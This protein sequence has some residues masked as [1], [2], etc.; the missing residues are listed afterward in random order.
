MRVVIDEDIP[1]SLTPRFRAGGY[2]VD[3][4]EDIGLKGTHNG[5]LLAAISGSADILVTGDTSLGHQQNLKLFDLAIILVRPPRLVVDQIIPLIPEVV[6]AFETAKRHA[7]TTIGRP[8]V[9]RSE[10]EPSASSPR[11][12]ATPQKATPK[13][14]AP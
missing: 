1:A 12:P 7:V 10:P 6:A 9:P 2:T 8:Q 3:H 11:K 13:K 14:P 5:V 4:V